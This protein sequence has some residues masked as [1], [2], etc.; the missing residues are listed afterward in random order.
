M[1]YFF[2]EKKFCETFFIKKKIIEKTNRVSTIKFSSKKSQKKIWKQKK[3][4]IISIIIL[5]QFQKLTSFKRKHKRHEKTRKNCRKIS[6]T[7]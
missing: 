3:V 7:Q 6:T 4:Y 5:E 1:K 2:I